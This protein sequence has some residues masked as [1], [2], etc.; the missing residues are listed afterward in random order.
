M[1]EIRVEV[2][3]Q[4]PPQRKGLRLKPAGWLAV[5]VLAFFVLVLLAYAGQ[6]IYWATHGIE[7][8][9]TMAPVPTYTP[10]P[11]PVPPTPTPGPTPTPEGWSRGWDPVTKREYLVPPP[12]VEQKVREA[13]N[14]VLAAAVVEDQSDDALRKYDLEEVHRRLAQ[15]ATSEI[16]DWYDSA[17]F[18]EIRPLAPE[19]PV[20]CSDYDT[21]TVTRAALEFRGY[22]IYDQKNCPEGYGYTAPC[23]VRTTGTGLRVFSDA[24]YG[25]A[26]IAVVERQEEKW[27]VVNWR[28]ESLPQPPSSP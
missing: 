25:R 7:T 15:Y 22:A 28:V 27:I 23:V 11:T 26:F 17:P 12:E 21:C 6:Q 4:M 19:G 20:Q 10:R 9:P 14:A 8:L 18:V 1:K 5:G 2:P 16:A 13:F 24:P 3:Q